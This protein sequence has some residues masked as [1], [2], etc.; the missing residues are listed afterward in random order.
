MAVPSSTYWNRSWPGRSWQRRISA[1]GAGRAGRPRGRAALALEAE[2]DLGAVDLDVPA[3]SVVRP[4][5][6]FSREYSSL[7]TRMSVSSRSR[8]TA[9]RTFSRGTRDGRGLGRRAFGCA[10]ARSRTRR[11]AELRL[12]ARPGSQDGS[13]AACGRVR[14]GRS[15]AGGRWARAD[16]HIGPRGRDHDRADPRDTSGRGSRFHPG[17]GS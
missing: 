11:A 8:T 16:P 14:R 13:D 3:R 10:A 15:P 7:P 2:A 12:V 17:R 9:A 5:D 4:K 1:R 6:W